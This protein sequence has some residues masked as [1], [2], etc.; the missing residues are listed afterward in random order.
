MEKKKQM[1]E[2]SLLGAINK[3]ILLGDGAMGTMLQDMGIS[4]C[5]DSLNLDEK[6]I[7]KV[8]GIH[9]GYLRAGSDIIQTNT[10]GANPVKLKSCK[11]EKDIEEINK[12]AVLAVKEAFKRY[13]KQENGEKIFIA[14]DI[15]PLGKLLEPAGNIGYG[16]AVEL[17][18]KQI[19]ALMEG[20][21][22]IL[23]ETIM[24][25]NEASAAIEAVKNV[26]KNI[27]IACTLTF[28]ENAVTMM[29]TKASNATKILQ[30]RGADIVGAN[31]SLGSK[32]MLKI[33]R[34]MRESDPEARL[35]FQPN[36]GMPVL[37]NGKTT[38]KESEDIMAENI[39]EYLQYKPS[40]IGACCGST[41]AHIK[42]IASLISPQ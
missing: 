34:E 30:E 12:N 32:L 25:I 29:G 8:I 35:M 19:E 33:I 22:F 21:D 9:L 3:K 5:P 2:E 4:A 20:I 38:Y 16:Q 26:D 42:K 41:P 28:G 10:F 7:E 14:G 11:L 17:F 27:P 37:E 24:D 13:T 40:I 18:S 31:C 39:K 15:G 23:I 1:T 36:A 6:Q